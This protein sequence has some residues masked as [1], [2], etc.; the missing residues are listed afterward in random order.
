M[1]PI[2][3]IFVCFISVLAA[4]AV[5]ASSKGITSEGRN[6]DAGKQLN[7]VENINLWRWFSDMHVYSGEKA[8]LKDIG[9]LGIVLF[10]RILGKN[11]YH[12]IVVMCAAANCA[13]AIMLYL[14]AALYWGSNVGLLVFGLYVTSFWSY[15]VVLQGAYQVLA[16]LFC[17]ITIYFL[18]FAGFHAASW[19]YY[20]VAGLTF[21]VMLFSSASARKYIWLVIAALIFNMRD[22]ILPLSLSGILKGNNNKYYML[23][24]IVIVL[25]ILLLV[26]LDRFLDK[27]IRSIY[28]GSASRWLKE[29]LLKEKDKFP[30]ETYFT[31]KDA[32]LRKMALLCLFLIAYLAFIPMVSFST[33]FYSGQ[34]LFISGAALIFIILTL[35]NPLNNLKGIY[36]YWTIS[37]WGGHFQ[38]YID[39]FAKK[40]IK[41]RKGQKG[42]GPIWYPRF[43]FR[44]APFASIYYFLSVM[45]I[46]AL[47][48]IGKGN[49][50]FFLAFIVG[51]LPII[52]TEITGGAKFGRTYFPTLIGLLFFIGYSASIIQSILH[53]YYL[54]LFWAFNAALIIASIIFNSRQF[55]SDILPSRMSNVYLLRKLNQLGANKFHTYNIPFNSSFVFALD[56]NEINNF[57]INF[58]KSISEAKDGYIIVPGTSS[59]SSIME[60]EDY[61]IE[62]GDFDEDPIL[63]EL[64]RTRRIKEFAVASFKTIG[65]SGI[66]G[67]EGEVPSYRDLILH[68][69][70]EE[71]R[72]RSLA[73][74][75]DAKKLQEGLAAVS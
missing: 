59:K 51:I 61:T 58:I 9:V 26:A 46:A 14:V 23:L 57:K 56:E 38:F 72:F 45:F 69:I 29:N 11:D 20:V 27:M 21:A 32:I 2:V 36:L 7:A 44:M 73:W 4:I 43:Y 55:F 13:A 37:Q 50:S 3:L 53:G 24:A 49:F 18:Y 15:Q 63:N 16:T 31:K 48:I 19:I 35:P 10:K 25:S 70:K 22:Y 41:V 75:L 60:S 34:L 67:Q 62:H 33:G 64:I 8:R 5:S 39:H 30:I 28:A 52:Y 65:S 66:W 1:N 54:S 17:L 68:E 6:S 42:G 12:T 47:F 71:D 40:G 74:I